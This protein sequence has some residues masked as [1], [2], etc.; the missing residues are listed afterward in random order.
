MWMK[1]LNQAAK[2][3]RVADEYDISETVLGQGSYGKVLKGKC[4]GSGEI[5][6][7]K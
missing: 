7:I 2:I 5:V 6:A 4:K 3:R 1:R